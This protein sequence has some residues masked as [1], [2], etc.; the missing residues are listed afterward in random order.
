MS[1]L[2]VVLPAYNEEEGLPPLLQAYA[3]LFARLE[4]EK[5]PVIIVVDD[6]STDRTAEVAQAEARHLP[7]RLVQHAENSGLGEAIKTGLRTA[8]E[9]SSDETDVIASMDADNTHPPKTLLRMIPRIHAG[10]DIVI[11]SRYRRGAR[12]IGVPP[13]RQALS[14]AAMVVFKAAFGL[15]GVRDFTCGF[16]AYRAGLVREAFN[17]YGDDLITRGGFAC[18]D[19]LLLRL[20]STNGGR[21]R[22]EEVPFILRYDRKA[23]GSKLRLGV[24]L[25]ETALLLLEG[26]RL[27]RDAKKP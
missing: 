18:T 14:I 27:L 2:I 4:T 19:E 9:E 15:P 6:G 22:I 12:Q 7:I 5:S 20:A 3:R 25:R 23:G 8:L 10:A 21:V 11:A 17:R 16:R 24:T 1:R 26:R 13:H